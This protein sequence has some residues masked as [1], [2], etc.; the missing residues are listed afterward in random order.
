MA[1][2]VSVRFGRAAFRSW[3]ALLADRLG[4]EL[5]AEVAVGIDLDFVP[6][7]LS[8]ANRSVFS[9]QFWGAAVCILFVADAVVFG[10]WQWGCKR[11]IAQAGPDAIGLGG[12]VA[13]AGEVVFAFFGGGVALDGNNATAGKMVN[14]SAGTVDSAPVG[15]SRCY[16]IERLLELEISDWGGAWAL[17]VK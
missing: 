3:V 4:S 14:H 7:R 9:D 10:K 12:T 17:L 11:S 1:L 6:E 16:W 5:D 8:F 2:A 15:A 13:V